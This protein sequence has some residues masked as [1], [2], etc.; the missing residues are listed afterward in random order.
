MKNTQQ[1]LHQWKVKKSIKPEKIRFI[2]RIEKLEDDG[3]VDLSPK[4]FNS[5]NKTLYKKGL[6][7]ICIPC[8]IYRVK[9]DSI[10]NLRRKFYEYYYD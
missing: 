2:S 4:I 9:S 7:I 3:L 5:E 10:I 1:L 6:C 8:K